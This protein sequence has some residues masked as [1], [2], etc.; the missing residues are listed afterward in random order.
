M[1]RAP[2]KDLKRAL[3]TQLAGPAGLESQE[4]SIQLPRKLPYRANQS[5]T[6]LH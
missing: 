6:Q 4:T 3:T 2:R 1:R 5:R